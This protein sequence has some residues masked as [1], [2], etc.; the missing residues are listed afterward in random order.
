M[1]NSWAYYFFYILLYI[2]SILQKNQAKKDETTGLK[3]TNDKSQACRSAD[4]E[5][6]VL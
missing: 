3:L 1:Q 2:T 5:H 4:S 6:S